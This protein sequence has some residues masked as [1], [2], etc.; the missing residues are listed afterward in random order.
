MSHLHLV[1]RTC[2]LLRRVHQAVCTAMLMR[3]ACS[4]LYSV[5]RLVTLNF[6]VLSHHVTQLSSDNSDLDRVNIPVS[7][8]LGQKGERELV[9]QS[10]KPSSPC[11]VQYAEP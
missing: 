11:H 6:N 1:T 3:D 5:C 7:A 10:A 8:C 9:G 4:L 2:S